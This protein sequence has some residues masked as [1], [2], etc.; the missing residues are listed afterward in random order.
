MVERNTRFLAVAHVENKRADTV[1][2]A[3]LSMFLHFPQAVKS[4]TLDNGTE[5]AQHQLLAKRLN[6]TV[7]FAHPH[8]LWERG[9][10]PRLIANSHC[11]AQ[12]R[13]LQYFPKKTDV[14]IDSAILA[15]CHQKINTRPRKCLNFASPAQHFFRCLKLLHQRLHF[16]G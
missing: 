13:A 3:I 2:N 7:Y 11:P 6:V 16:Y 10:F 1:R 12:G 5:F 9:N 15:D 4:I 8:A 14:V